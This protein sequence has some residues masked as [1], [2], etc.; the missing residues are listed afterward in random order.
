MAAQDERLHVL[1]V[2]EYLP[3]YV[4][5]IANRCK[6]WIRGFKKEGHRVTVVGCIG[7]ECDI[8]MWSMKN[9]WYDQQRIF[10]CPPWRL[11]S[12]VLNPMESVSYDVLHIVAPLNL[13]I[14]PLIP[15]F[16][17]RGVKIYVSYH[18]YMEFYKR[19]Y[20]YGRSIFRKLL[21]DFI[22]VIYAVVYFVPLVIFAHAVG[23]PSKTYDGVVKIASEIHLLKSGLN[24]DVFR[25]AEDNL[26][27]TDVL[28]QWWY[29]ETHESNFLT[30]W[31]ARESR[32]I[33]TQ[34]P[35][36][37]VYVGRLASEKGVDFLIKALKHND[38]SRASLVIVGDGP[39]RPH[40]ETLARL[41]VEPSH[42]WSKPVNPGSP[43]SVPTPLTHRVIFTGMVHSE[44]VLSK[45][46]AHAT[47]FVSSSA[48]ETFG[49][50]VAEA[51]ACGIPAV[52]VRAGAF[53]SV[54]ECI[55][56]WMYNENDYEDYAQKIHKVIVDMSAQQR[57][58]RIAIENFSLNVGVRDLLR[59]YKQLVGK[60]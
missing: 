1:L 33:A 18:V 25:P 30:T 31:E 60:R 37:L 32:K 10:L 36:V 35:L 29:D 53:R 46:Y 2:T 39:S 52:V 49:F 22:H 57:S 43:V 40:L 5:G 9:L 34:I 4:S 24:T 7:T 20:F 58:R 42:V 41:T 45:L 48:S 44:N 54:Y 13:A 26:T 19:A 56:D 55:D 11:I 23:V 16:A 59:K 8:E 3:P 51:L 50:T 21:G 12:E 6:Y 47:V 38:L 15:F 17:L 14:V 28:E 27:F